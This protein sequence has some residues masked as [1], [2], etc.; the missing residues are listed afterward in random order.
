[1][2]NRVVL[3]GRLVRDP[4][5]S[6]TNAGVAVAKFTVAWSEKYKDKETKLFLS[7]VAWRNTAEFL[8]QYFKKGQELVVEGKLSSRDYENKE[9]KKVYVTELN[10]D[11]VSFC[12]S[13]ASGEAGIDT[14]AYTEDLPF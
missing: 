7:C 6:Y 3:Q 2:I 8:A 11:N 12:G 9:G 14:S 1:M 13:K 5:I 10:V 4:E